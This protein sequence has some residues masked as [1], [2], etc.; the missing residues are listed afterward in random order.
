MSL[1]NRD[2]MPDD[3]LSA[4]NGKVDVRPVA[5]TVVIGRGE[6][7]AR[8]ISIGPGPH[9]ADMLGIAAPAAGIFFVSDIHV[10]T[11]DA[12]EPRAGRGKTEC[13]FAGWAVGAL[14]DDVRVVNSHSSTVTPVAR[15]RAYLDSDSCSD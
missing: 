5:E 12:D 9:S 8:L 2:V 4:A 14:D 11:S 7:S 1:L 3:A 13:W 10:P 6:R 15:L